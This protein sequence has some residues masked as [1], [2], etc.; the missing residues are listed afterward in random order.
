MWGAESAL[1]VCYSISLVDGAVAQQPARRAAASP[2]A[3]HL[4]PASYKS[5]S[6]ESESSRLRWIVMPEPRVRL[7]AEVC[8]GAWG[9]GAAWFETCGGVSYV[10]HGEMARC[11]Q[12]LVGS[13]ITVA[14]VTAVIAAEASGHHAQPS[15]DMAL[16]T[17]SSPYP[18]CPQLRSLTRTALTCSSSPFSASSDTWPRIC[19]C[20]PM[21][22]RSASTCAASWGRVRAIR[23]T[24]EGVSGSVV[25]AHVGWPLTALARGRL[26]HGLDHAALHLLLLGGA[27]AALLVIAAAI[28]AVT[29][30]A[31][32]RAGRGLGWAHACWKLE[33][34]V[35]V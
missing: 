29:A 16:A 24:G 14:P 32:L 21:R 31:A 20:W 7:R 30:V 5:Y 2:S 3:S 35:V 4:A 18:P 33:G 9:L 1:R 23:E 28:V 34:H 8:C 11:R 17:A 25:L 15:E 27:G 26:E 19:P 22:T 13:L 10:W 12:K 6:S